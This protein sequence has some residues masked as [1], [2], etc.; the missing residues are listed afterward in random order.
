MTGSPDAGL[1]VRPYP[2]GASAAR[3]AGSRRR[4]AGRA[5]PSLGLVLALVPVFFSACATVRR[6]PLE[7]GSRLL[8]VVQD[9]DSAAAALAAEADVDRA[10]ALVPLRAW[11]SGADPAL[12]DEIDSPGRQRVDL[13]R[14]AAERRRLPWLLVLDGRRIRIETAR[15]GLVRWQARVVPGRDRAER[16]ARTLS[17]ALPSDRHLGLGG[18]G[19]VRLAPPG[20]LAALRELVVQ[21]R[22]QEYSAEVAAM[23]AAWPADPAIRTHAGLREHLASGVGSMAGLEL[24]AAM[25]PGAESELLAVALAADGA[26]AAAVGLAV[27]RALVRLEPDRL[28]YRPGLAEA[29]Q[30]VGEPDEALSACR[31][32]M[33]R[34]DRES[35]VDLP[36][37]TAPDAAPGAVAFA[38]VAFCTGLHLYEAEQFEASAMAYEDAVAV[39]QA[40]GLRPELGEALNNAG[41]AMVGAGSP[42]TATRVLLKAVA[43]REEIGDPLP[44]ANSRY[45]L[46]RARSE[47]NQVQEALSSFDAAASDYERAGEP[48]DALDALVETLDLYVRDGDGDG[49]ASRA[50]A[51]VAALDSLPEGDGR[52][53]L[54]GNAWFEIGKGRLT[55]GDARGSL[56]A[57]LASLRAWERLG[58]RLEQGQTHYSLALP[59]MA[60][61]EFGEAHA[62]L[63]RALGIAVDLGDAASILDIGEQLRQVESLIEKAGQQVPEIPED[64]QRWLG[65]GGRPEIERHPGDPG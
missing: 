3:A 44:L 20:R 50:G 63:L 43:V 51:I 26:G 35:F 30:A 59:H 9:A 48:Q 27:R 38:D 31:E 34:A 15:E 55:F 16:V 41:A 61:F 2:P 4:L 49:F 21:S 5:W 23:L 57:Y 10:L 29:L 53:L 13:A 42:L 22:L 8:V 14:G 37:G 17:L 64:L 19:E 12:G 36:A 24:A 39:F 28:D 33:Q 18:P 45:N 40:T 47:A 60:M 58:L 25:V 62:D 32:G 52:E 6:L 1:A 7:P 56:A 46:G 11:P 65:R 54:R